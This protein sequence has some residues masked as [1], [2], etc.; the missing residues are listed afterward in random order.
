MTNHIPQKTE[1]ASYCGRLIEYISIDALFGH[2]DEIFQQRENSSVVQEVRT[3]L[4]K[5]TKRLSVKTR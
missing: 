1:F 3:V 4:L 5:V 2:F